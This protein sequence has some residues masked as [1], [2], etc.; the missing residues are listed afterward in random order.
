MK[1]VSTAQ[2]KKILDNFQGR[3]DILHDCVKEIKKLDEKNVKKN[4]TCKVLRGGN[5]KFQKN[6]CLRWRNES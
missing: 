6:G 3:R 5:C 1:K 2:T 4:K